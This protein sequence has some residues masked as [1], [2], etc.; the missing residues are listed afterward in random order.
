MDLAAYRVQFMNTPTH[1]VINL[2]L[3]HRQRQPKW[4]GLIVWGALIPD[5][6]MFGFYLWLRLVANMPARQIWEV[7]YFLPGWQR[8]FDLSHSLPLALLGMGLMR[9]IQRPGWALLF[10]SMALHSLGDLPVHHD[11]AHRHFLPL[12]NFR[13]ES[14]VSYWDSNHYGDIFRPFEMGLLLVAS[15]YM[16]SRVRSRAAKGL[17]IAVNALPLLAHLYFSAGG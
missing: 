7:A 13:F 3:L 8:V 2:A 16:F 1:A 6:S 15:V 17:L 4:N 5:L 14:P 9:Y 12:S 10:A 11:D